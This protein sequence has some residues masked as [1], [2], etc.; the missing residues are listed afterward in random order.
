MNFEN[1]KLAENH[2]VEISHNSSSKK[3]EYNGK[4]LPKDDLFLTGDASIEFRSTNCSKSR[5]GQLLSSDEGFLLNITVT[6]TSFFIFFFL[7]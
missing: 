4:I 2:C 1:L 5:V 3:Y 6:G 7:S